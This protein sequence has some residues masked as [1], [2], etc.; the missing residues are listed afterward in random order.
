MWQFNVPHAS[1][2]SGVVESLIKSCRKAFD[3]TCNY[4]KVAYTQSEWETI[5]F[6]VNYS[7]NSRLLFSKTVEN[8]D[9]EP[10]SGNTLLY[11]YGQE[12]MPQLSA[13]YYVDPRVSIKRPQC[14]INTFWDS[15]MRNMPPH[16][17][18]RNK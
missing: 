10:F 15:W 1:H 5:I 17:L 12:P 9:E 2:M 14:F 3:S 13:P 8:L 4:H 18:L 6:E 16:L 7:V 11:P